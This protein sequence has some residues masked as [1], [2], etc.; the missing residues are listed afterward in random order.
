LVAVSSSGSGNRIMTSDDGI[1]WTLRSTPASTGWWSICW[2]PQRRQFAAVSNSGAGNR[3][4][5][6]P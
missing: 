2:S 1:T 5:V 6:S 4:M 3:V